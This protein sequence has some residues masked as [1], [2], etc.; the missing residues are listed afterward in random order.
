MAKKSQIEVEN[1]LN[2]VISLKI[3]GLSRQ[4][5]FDY[6][7]TKGKINSLF[8]LDNYIRK[9]NKY[10]EK[11]ADQ[12]K[13][14]IIGLM[15]LRYENLYQSFQK[16][17]DYRGC[18]QILKEYREMYFNKNVASEG[19]QTELIKALREFAVK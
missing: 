17:K 8:T 11:K 18:L 6:L 2:D 9:A 14:K 12:K 16:I 5:I 13:D 15:M 10:I 19:E 4:E 1:L 7:Q 3:K